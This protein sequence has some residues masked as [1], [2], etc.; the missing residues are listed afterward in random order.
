[1]TVIDHAAWLYDKD[2]RTVTV[3]ATDCTCV[4]WRGGEMPGRRYEF[5]WIAC[6][7][8]KGTGKRGN[9]K[10]RE[11]KYHRPSEYGTPRERPGYFIGA[12]P[13]YA[14]PYDAGPCGQC[15]GT[16]KVPGDGNARMP[17]DVL[18]AF[19]ADTP[20]SVLATDARHSWAEYNL[21]HLRIDAPEVRAKAYMVSTDYGQRWAVLV[22]AKADGRL[23]EAVEDLRLEVEAM[24][25]KDSKSVCNW[26]LDRAGPRDAG[27][28]WELPTRIVGMVSPDG[29]RLLAVRDR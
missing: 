20:V 29:L 16:L 19:L 17:A 2:A 15:D 5:P 13:D 9:G 1:M 23:D 18:A 14:N 21:G 3:G 6:V 22:K 7:K 8:C 26:A 4:T 24:V 12:V 28:V 10:C 25:A 27:E 11:C